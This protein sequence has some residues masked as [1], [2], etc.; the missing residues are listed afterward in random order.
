MVI[1]GGLLAGFLVAVVAPIIRNLL[2][3]RVVV[4]S[5]IPLAMVR[6]SISARLVIVGFKLVRRPMSI[7]MAA[8]LI[9]PVN[10]GWWHNSP[11]LY[12][13]IEKG[14]SRGI[15]TKEWRF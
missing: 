4:L 8:G 10:S 2:S 13:V 7:G 15:E 9:A 6:F 3:M 14:Y 1:H 12:R 11:R 5:S